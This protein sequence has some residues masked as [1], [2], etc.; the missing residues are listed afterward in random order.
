MALSYKQ[1]MKTKFEEK[2]KKKKVSIKPLY[3]YVRP[4]IP[5]F[6]LHIILYVNGLSLAN[7]A[8]RVNIHTI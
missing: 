1:I 2:K 8:I 5:P 3:V 7:N 6:F 4:T